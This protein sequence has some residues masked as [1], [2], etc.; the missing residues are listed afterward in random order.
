MY[1]GLDLGTSSV[2]AI[3]MNEKGDVVTTHSV[4]LAISALTLNGQNKIPCNGGMLQ[5][6][7]L[8]TS[9]VVFRWNT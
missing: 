3:I 7:P 1:L 9:D 8:L 6:K 5:K 2:K 4:P